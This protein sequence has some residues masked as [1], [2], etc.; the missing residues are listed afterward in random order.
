MDNTNE[1]VNNG[2]TH[3]PDEEL[4]AVASEKLDKYAEAF[5]ELAK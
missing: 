4:L 3:I 5:E 1:N 2:Y